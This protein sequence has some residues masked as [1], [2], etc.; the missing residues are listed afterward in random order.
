MKKVIIG[1]LAMGI[2][3][4]LAGCNNTTDNTDKVKETESKEAIVI[5]YD[6]M[7]ENFMVQL[8]PDQKY[9]L[10]NNGTETE[11]SARTHTILKSKQILTYGELK[12]DL[13]ST[14]YY[15]KTEPVL[16][17]YNDKDYIWVC[18][19]DDSGELI[20]ASFF[21]ITEYNSFGSDSGYVNMKIGDE[22]LDPADFVMN[23]NVNCF[24]Y[25]TSKV[26]YEI[27][28]LGK[29]A[30]LESDDEYYYLEP[31][32]TEELLRLDDDIHTWVYADEN[33]TE[34]TVEDVPAGTTFHRLRIPKNA[35][36]SYV[37]AILEDGRVMRVVEEY[38][39]SEPE[40]YQAMLDK[41]AN[42]FNYSTVQAE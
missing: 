12:Y 24:G 36:Y 16:I 41:D 27:N 17:R 18:E 6:K 40:A 1:V 9:T 4:L 38:W 29:P 14:V 22:V 31:P 39:F 28:E 11:F 2:I 23:K 26:H 37:E 7:P 19:E 35:E 5:D 32:Y 15:R 30:E 20:S 10:K 21:Y 42:Q 8:L 3:S 13:S 33:A 25:V 34:S